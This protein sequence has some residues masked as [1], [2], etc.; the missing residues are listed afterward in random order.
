SVTDA[1]EGINVRSWFGQRDGGLF[2]G[3]LD[4]AVRK[5]KATN[6]PKLIAP[7]FSTDNESTELEFF[8]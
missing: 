3:F 5:M 2:V 1:P 4:G 7:Y 8:P 6:A